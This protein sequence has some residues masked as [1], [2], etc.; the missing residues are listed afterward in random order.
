M[1]FDVGKHKEKTSFKNSQSNGGPAKML[2]VDL[3]PLVVPAPKSISNDNRCGNRRV[4]KPMKQR[5]FEVIYSAMSKP[6][7]ECIYHTLRDFAANP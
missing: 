2:Q 7:I 3:N 4:V 1:P 6:S 5:F